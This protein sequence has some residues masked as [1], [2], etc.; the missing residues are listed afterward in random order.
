M[1]TNTPK[2]SMIPNFLFSPALISAIP[3]SIFIFT[4]VTIPLTAAKSFGLTADQTATWIAVMHLSQGLLSVIMSYF[5]GQPLLFAFAT[6]GV[7]FAASFSGVHQFSDLLGA[8]MVS[9][10]AVIA[11]A[12]L[13]LGRRLAYWLP[14]PIVYAMLA[15]AIFPYVSGIFSSINTFPVPIGSALV[16]YILGRRF[17]NAKIPAILPTLA[18]AIVEH[19][20]Q[21]LFSRWPL[22]SGFLNSHGFNPH[23]H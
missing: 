10:I 5:Y 1:N 13:G 8:A 2:P 9:G 15:G 19:T 17:L 11:L 16:V 20:S 21:G 23:F 22:N 18:V 7:I 4:A 6:G 3:V 12:S 14:A